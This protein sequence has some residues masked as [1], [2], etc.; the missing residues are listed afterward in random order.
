MFSNESL[1]TTTNVT[2][3]KNRSYTEKFSLVYFG[4]FHAFEVNIC[5]LQF[6]DSYNLYNPRQI[7]IKIKWCYP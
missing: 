6:L 2:L 1:L 4:S 7:I 5:R 3:N